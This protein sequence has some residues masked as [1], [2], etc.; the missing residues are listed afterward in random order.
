VDPNQKTKRNLSMKKL[1]LIAGTVLVLG[2]SAT[3]TF[4][5][6]LW[7]STSLSLWANP[8]YWSAGLPNGASAALFQDT[9][10]VGLL[11]TIDVSAQN[12]ITRGIG[13]SPS[14]VGN[15]FTIMSSAFPSVM[16]VNGGGT[17]DG[18]ANNDSR[19]QTISVPIKIYSDNGFSGNG[20]AQTWNAA[21]GNLI[22]SGIYK[23]TPATV[24][25]NGGML[26]ISG[27]F[28]TTIGATIGTN[29]GRGDI[30]GV[31][32]L[33]KTGSGTL[34][35]GGANANTYSGGTILSAGTGPN[36]LSF[37]N[38]SSLSS[39]WTGALTIFNWNQAN[40]RLRFG[41]DATGLT[42]S[43][44]NNILFYGWSYHPTIN[45]SGYLVIPEPSTLALCLLGGLA[46][47][48]R[49]NLRAR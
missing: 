32:G 28:N 34:F 1:F 31:G 2:S 48:L 40:D 18:I 8:A 42:V 6:T 13:F 23:G 11:H 19:T 21:A 17:Y 37:A 4:A 45:S 30:V 7:N 22:F 36:T 16:Q 33:T 44:L 15:G 27:G 41:T 3:L 26:T 47:A 10:T 35:L 46:L 5:D 43:Q 14:L 39:L 20:A 49:R 25:N 38:S 29:T 9:G 12:T 24:D